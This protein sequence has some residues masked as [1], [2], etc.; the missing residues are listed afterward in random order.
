MNFVRVL[1][2]VSVLLLVIFFATQVFIPIWMGRPLFPLFRRQ[3]KLLKD[4]EF[5]KEEA[6]NRQLEREARKI[7]PK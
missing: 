2:I 6:E 5:A 7:N 1:E 4:V 3:R